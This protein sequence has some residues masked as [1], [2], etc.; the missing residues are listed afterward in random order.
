M[1]ECQC[2]VY[3]IRQKVSGRSYVGQSIDV[4]RRWEEHKRGQGNCPSLSAAL[5]KYGSEAFD[6]EVLE[7]CEPAQLNLREAHHIAALCTLSPFGYNLRSGGGQRE[8]VSEESR[9]KMSEAFGRSEAKQTHLRRIHSDP[10]V[11]ARKSESA[12]GSERAKA[13]RQRMYADPEVQERRRQALIHSEKAK[14]QRARLHGRS[15]E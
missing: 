3:V 4:A 1:S 2:G 5:L 9:R 8:E 11:L 14:A 13:Q 6:F 10:L 12:R 7:I 15:H